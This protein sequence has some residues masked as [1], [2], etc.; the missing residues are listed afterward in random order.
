MQRRNCCSFQENIWITTT[1]E[2]RLK[3][4]HLERNEPFI[5][6]NVALNYQD[7]Y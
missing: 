1:D 2:H 5:A 6:E 7:H 4:T 3:T